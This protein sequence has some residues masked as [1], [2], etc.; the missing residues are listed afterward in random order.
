[1]TAALPQATPTAFVFDKFDKRGASGRWRLGKT[2]NG[3]MWAD[4]EVR[5]KPGWRVTLRAVQV[6]RRQGHL[7]GD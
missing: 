2:I 3:R 6:L 1:M 4:T 5:G 7:T